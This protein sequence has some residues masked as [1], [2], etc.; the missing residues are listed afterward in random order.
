MCQRNGDGV[1]ASAGAA[2]SIAG[3]AA[4]D[5][6][7][8]SRGAG[9]GDGCSAI[10]VGFDL[11]WRPRFVKSS[12]MHPVALLQ[13]ATADR[14]V[15]LYHIRHGGVILPEMLTRLLACNGVK[16]VRLYPHSVNMLSSA[17]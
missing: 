7:V 17:G 3:S 10:S 14:A 2:G 4:T 6:P 15:L 5:S 1:I 12:S 9:S 16:K 8:S 13:I 11:E